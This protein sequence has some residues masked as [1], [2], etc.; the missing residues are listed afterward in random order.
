[1]SGVFRLPDLHAASAGMFQH[2]T[3]LWRGVW[4]GFGTFT[5]LELDTDRIFLHPVDGK[6]CDQLL[7]VLVDL[8]VLGTAVGSAT[9]SGLVRAR[10]RLEVGQGSV[11]PGLQSGGLVPGDLLSL[12][13]TGS[14]I[15]SVGQ[16]VSH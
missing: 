13:H 5:C 15:I 8:V 10:L 12:Q 4:A 1:M 11:P 9:A 6:A 2:L 3:A 14:K 16:I 7:G